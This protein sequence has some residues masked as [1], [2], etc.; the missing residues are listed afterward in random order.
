MLGHQWVTWD[1]AK[2]VLQQPRTRRGDPNAP[3][4]ITINKVGSLVERTISRLTKSAPVP[5]CRPV[6]NEDD[7]VS[8]AKVGTRILAHE[9]N[10]LHWESLLP[11]L[12]FWVMPVGWSFIHVT[13]DPDDGEI[14]GEDEDGVVREGQ[15]GLEIVPALEVRIDPNARTWDEARWC[16]R[17][18]N[19]TK[20][21]IYEQYGITNIEGDTNL[22]RDLANDINALAEGTSWDIDKRHERRKQDMIAVHQLWMLP[23]GRAKPEGLVFTW[24]GGTVLEDPKPFPYEHGNLPFVPFSLLPG[25]GF[26]EGRTWVSDLRGMQMDYND[27][28]SR[29]ATIRRTLVPKILAARGQIDPARMTS[30]VETVE[31]NPTGPEPKW[32]VPDGGWMQQYE[33]A[34]GR[35]DMEMG[36]RAGQAEVSQGRAPAGAPAAAILALQEADESKLAISAKELGVS[37]ERIGYQVLML[38]RQFWQE[39]RIVRAWSET[40]K[41]DVVRFSGSDL[42]SQMDVHVSAESLMPKSKSARA[43]LA[44][45]LW[46]RQILSDPAQFIRMIEIPGVGFLQDQ[47]DLDLRQAEREHERILSG[48][49]VQ[50]EDWHNHQAHIHAHNNYRKTPEYEAWP[51]EAKALMDQH[52]MVHYAWLQY[53]ATGQLPAG[54]AGGQLPGTAGGGGEELPEGG[55]MPGGGGPAY[56]DPLTGMPPDPLAVASGQAP[57]ALTM[58]PPGAL[59]GAGPV[60]GMST[61]SQAAR[62]GN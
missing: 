58:N 9:L 38:V 17:S 22:V 4:R 14:F 8:T 1:T 46:D 23:G 37:I 44:L 31:Y 7:D 48:E 27:A 30:R 26:P 54:I 29:E 36:D 61:D 32:W 39:E 24:T 51:D 5:E 19:M 62:Q 2:R 28:R 34:M 59:Q 43:Q 10:R 20:E 33:Q 45:D 55:G 16:V 41:L 47:F 50:P 56:L 25:V 3:V 52:I 57:S 49:P 15:V 35:A 42:P 12:Y 11:R 53:Q 18:V 60:P 13:W 6:T 21:A 40:G